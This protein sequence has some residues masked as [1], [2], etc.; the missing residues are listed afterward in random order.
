MISS[1]SS[2]TWFDGAS[3]LHLFSFWSIH[4]SP[5]FTKLAAHH[6]HLRKTLLWHILRRKGAQPSF[7]HNGWTQHVEG[8]VPASLLACQTTDLLPG[9]LLHF[10][11]TYLGSM[12][13]VLGLANIPLSTTFMNSVFKPFALLPRFSWSRVHSEVPVHTMKTLFENWFS[14]GLV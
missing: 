2:K 8:G 5:L 10:Q 6:M 12:N 14:P 3:S 13:I 4:S 1:N 7:L 9:P 11:T